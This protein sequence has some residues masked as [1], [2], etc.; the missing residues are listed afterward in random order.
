[1][2]PGIA[3]RTLAALPAQAMQKALEELPRDTVLL[4]FGYYRT[5]D[6]QS[7]SMKESLQRLRSWTD[8]PMYS[9]WSGQLGKGVLAGQCEFNEFHAVH[10]AH[11][12]LSVLGGTPPDAIPLLHEPS[13]YLIYDHAVL[14]RYGISESDLPPDSVI[15]NR[16]LSFY[17]QH[18]AALLPAMTIMLVLFGIILLLMYL[19]RVKQ[20]SESLLR[21]E[22]AVLAQANA[23]ERRSQLERRMEAIGRMAGGITHDVNN[24]LGGIAACA[25]LAL[26]EIPREN[27]AYEDVLHILDATV[28]G[29]DLMKQ[30]RMT[31]STKTLDARSETP[32]VS[33]LIRECAETLQPQ[34]PPHISLNVRNACPEA[35]IRA[36][37]V[38]VH[39]VLLNLCLNA[40]QAMPDG[41]VRGDRAFPLTALRLAQTPRPHALMS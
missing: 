1:M 12:V 9:P 38:E 14:T 41:G 3:V 19:L 26:P 11:M 18:R 16:P 4:N 27:P 30:I 6:G 5:A 35:R 17:E 15:I 33:K 8:L 24:I 7:Y 22:K 32:L 36:V 25:Q 31:D 21:Q 39:Q 2:K 10:A 28:R 37:S 23:L 29:K 40:I 20:R 34:L 13:P